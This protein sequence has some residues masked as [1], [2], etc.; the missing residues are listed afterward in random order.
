MSLATNAAPVLLLFVAMA[1]VGSVQANGDSEDIPKIPIVN[2]TIEKIVLA[3]SRLAGNVEI[4]F[5]RNNAYNCGLTG[6]YTFMVINPPGS[7]DQDE[8]PLWVYM[9]SGGSGYWDD[10]GKYFALNS[11]TEDTWNHE[12]TV[13][14]LVLTLSLRGVVP[15]GGGARQHPH[16]SSEGGLPDVGGR[17]VRPRSVPW[18]G[19]PVPEQPK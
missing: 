1:A 17:H 14:D 12:E 19:H 9:H 6:Q 15:G 4:D 10:D 8:A 18:Y 16:A 3:E 7:G 5:F 13:D 11:Q 2:R